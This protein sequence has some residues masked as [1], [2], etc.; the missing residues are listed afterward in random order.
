MNQNSHFASDDPMFL[1]LLATAVDGIIVIDEK[2]IAQVYNP[3]CQRL[4][5]YAAEEVIGHNVNMLMPSPYHEEHDSY[6]KHYR[7]TG[8]KRIIGIGREV[9]GRRKNGSTFPFH[10]SVGEGA[11]NGKKIFVGII[12][13]LTNLAGTRK[14]LNEVQSELLHVSRLSDMAQMVAA[15]AHEL[16][17]PLA[18]IMNY[19]KAAKRTLSSVQSPQ[20]AKAEELIDKAANQTGRAGKI[21]RRLRDFI[22]KRDS[23]REEE[24]I[25]AVLREAIE[26]GLVGAAESGVNVQVDLMADPPPVTMDRVQIQQVV[27]NLIRNSVDAMR[28]VERRSLSVTSCTNEPGFIEIAVSDTGPGLPPEVAEKL[29]QPF[30]TTKD[31]GMG[32]GLAICQSIVGAHDG[33]IWAK[34][35]SEG[36]VVFGFKLP[37]GGQ[38]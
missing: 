11:L 7:S 22:E 17:Q 33:E 12:H 15:L 34:P 19:I 27:L 20:Q 36:G 14:R 29:F 38:E 9:I 26:L 5:G 1:T 18:A 35:N 4:F 13:D 8:E 24:D 31:D 28:S 16:N 25:N 21:I 32:V 37:T 2:G 10:L 3:A 6:L 23:A 30:V